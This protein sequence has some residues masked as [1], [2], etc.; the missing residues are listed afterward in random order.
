MTKERDSIYVA[1]EDIDFIWSE[2][3]VK[4]FRMM[5]DSDFPV[6]K[7]AERLKRSIDDVAMLVY[8][9]ALRRKIKPRDGGLMGEE[10]I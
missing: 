4:K 3:E 8:D 5:W 6:E 1:L 7:I 10:S 9:Q 2:K